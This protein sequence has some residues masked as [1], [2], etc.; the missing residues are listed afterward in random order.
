MRP[1][2]EPEKQAWKLAVTTA[3]F[4]LLAWHDSSS[5]QLQLIVQVQQHV[6]DAVSKGARALTG[7]SKPSLQAPY[8]KGNFFQPTV[9]SDCTIDMK[10]CTLS[11]AAVTLMLLYCLERLI[12]HCMLS[13]VCIGTRVWQNAEAPCIGAKAVAH[14]TVQ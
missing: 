11:T 1:C 3:T 10:V 4:T 8:D 12:H 9:L 2:K 7:G 5:K 14:R 6:D 13:R